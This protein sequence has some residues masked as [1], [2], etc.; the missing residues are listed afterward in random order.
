MKGRTIFPFAGDSEVQAL[1][2]RLLTREIYC[3][4]TDIQ[5]KAGVKV[6]NTVG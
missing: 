2:K 4:C 3:G 5:G 1:D 6:L